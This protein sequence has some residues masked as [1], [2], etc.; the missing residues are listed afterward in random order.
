MR[1]GANVSDIE[2]VLAVE[3]RGLKFAFSRNSKP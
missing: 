2:R 3:N 1:M